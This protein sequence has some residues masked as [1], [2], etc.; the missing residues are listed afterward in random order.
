MV[1]RALVFDNSFIRLWDTFTKENCD[2]GWLNL[3]LD[4]TEIQV[5]FFGLEVG[6][7]RPGNKCV[8]KQ[9]NLHIIDEYMPHSVY[10]R[11]T[12]NML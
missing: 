3:D 11:K 1:Q 6:T 9:Q 8:Q 7:V 5:D 12:G 10:L 4:G 2:R